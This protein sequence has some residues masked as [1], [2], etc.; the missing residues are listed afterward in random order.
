MIDGLGGTAAGTGT[1]AALAGQQ[2]GVDVGQGRYGMLLPQ[3]EP[4]RRRRARRLLFDRVQ[5]RET[6]QRFLD[7]GATA[8]G[9]RVDELAPHMGQASQFHRPRRK[10]G[11]VAGV[12]VDHQMTAPALQEGARVH[13]GP[14]GLVVEDDHGW[15]VVQHIGT[16]CPQVGVFYLAAA[17]VQLSHRRFIG[18]Q[19]TSLPEQISEPAGQ[20]LQG[21]TDPF[22]QCGARQLADAPMAGCSITVANTRLAG[23]KIFVYAGNMGVAQGMGVLLDLAERLRARD[24]I[25]FLFVGPGTDRD[26][27]RYDAARRQL[28]NVQFFDEIDRAEIPGL[29]QQCH[30]GIVALDR[31]HKTHNIPGKFLSYMQTGLPVLASINS[32]NDL[33]ALIS[34][35]RVGDTCTDASVDTLEALAYRLGG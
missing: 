26:R 31:R 1:D 24:D 3:C 20:R 5:L 16:V 17:W 29:Y 35:E 23:R 12:I 25:G 15:A 30:A 13:A 6:T 7:D 4:V 11:F 32:G 21:D 18:M 28:N 34:G 27:L 10:Q 9:A 14:P 33:A 22:G 8:G 2:P 19:T